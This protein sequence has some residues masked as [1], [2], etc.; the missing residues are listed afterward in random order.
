M[1]SSR[2]SCRC[3]LREM[4]R[5]IRNNA[6][7][8]EGDDGDNNRLTNKMVPVQIFSPTGGR[9]DGRQGRGVVSG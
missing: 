8:L 4:L 5:R 6:E 2:P 9:R 1:A 7:G 3:F